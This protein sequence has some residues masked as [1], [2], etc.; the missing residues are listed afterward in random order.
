MSVIGGLLLVGIAAFCIL[1]LG[2]KQG[3]FRW[4]AEDNWNPHIKLYQVAA[5]FAV[6]FVLSI[7]APSLYVALLR[8]YF[9]AP[10]AFIGYATWINFLLSGTILVG[11][12]ILWRGLPQ[13]VRSSLW[14]S[15]S[16]QQPYAQ[17]LQMSFFAW[18]LSFPVVLFVNQLM[19]DFLYRV[20]GVEQIPDQIAVRFIKMTA[21]QPFYFFLAI[22]AVVILA[23]LIEEFLFRGLLQSFIRKH[24]GSKQAI[25]ITALCF[26]CFHLSWE[27]GW[28][29][30]S[31]VASLFP[32]A[33]FLGFLY[34]KQRS[35]LSPIGLH[36]LFNGL[37]IANLYFFGGIPCA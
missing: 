25:F 29:N 23:P 30:V 9:Q 13:D 31:I 24:L 3:F 19:E 4:T 26:S 33:L 11:L 7:L 35:L 32:L 2:W 17:D 20:L 15:R 34:E 36:S 21:E 16:A 37:S 8:P 10:D 28:G 12:F 14:R 22:I 18:C 1:W 27:Q 6:Y 5:G